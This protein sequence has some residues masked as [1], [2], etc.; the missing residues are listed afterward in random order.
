MTELELGG[1]DVV[2]RWARVGEA[3][4]NKERAIRGAEG[5]WW[6]ALEAWGGRIVE[7]QY[8]AR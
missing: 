7:V 2:R 3:R 1:R 8:D 4:R 5:E 6:V